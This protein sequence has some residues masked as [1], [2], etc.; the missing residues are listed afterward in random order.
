[1]RPQRK[2]CSASPQIFDEPRDY[3]M[4]DAIF[5]TDARNT[6]NDPQG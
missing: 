5:R 1:M 3:N 6:V 2:I 4:G